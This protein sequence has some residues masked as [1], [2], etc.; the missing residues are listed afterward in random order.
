MSAKSDQ[1]SRLEARCPTSVYM[2]VK[3]AAELQGRSISD[4]VVAAAHEAARAA[5]EEEG[6]T[7]LAAEDSQRFAE[8]LLAP[9]QPDE[10][11]KRAVRLHREQV[12]VR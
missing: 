12:E 8:A 4:F 6:I 7:R 9:P 3:R 1:V 10:A 11:L 2:T 5:I